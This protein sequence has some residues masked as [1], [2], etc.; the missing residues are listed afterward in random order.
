MLAKLRDVLL[1]HLV[2]R[3]YAI[4]SG[5][6]AG[7]GTHLWAPNRLVI[8][9]N[10]YMGRHSQIEC[11]AVIG[12]FV[13]LGN[14][15][16]LVGKYDHNFEEVGTPVRETLGIRSPQYQ[17]KGR[18]L[19]VTIG[20]DVWIGLGSIVLSGTTIGEGSVIAAGS[21]VTRDVEEYSIYAGNPARKIRD[22]FPSAADRERH[23]HAI[24]QGKA[25]S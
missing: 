25:P 14:F 4:G 10:F 13:M 18:G 6:H 5:F 8:G 11:D 9:K 15:V 1:R 21:V 16:C 23:R 7:R 12:D 22:R 24:R 2:Y 19:Q 20:D 3:K 17:W